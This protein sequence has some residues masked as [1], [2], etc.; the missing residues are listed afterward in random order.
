MLQTLRNIRFLVPLAAV[1]MLGLASKAGAQITNP[2]FETGDYTG[3]TTPDGNAT[4]ETA[5]TAGET[6]TNGTFE[7]EIQT[8]GTAPTGTTS[9]GSPS[10][11]DTVANLD[12]Y[13]GIGTTLAS[14]PNNFFNGSAFKQT[15][16]ANAGS[17]LSFDADFLTDEPA[18]GG[19][20]DQAFAFLLNGSTIDD[21]VSLG[22]PAQALTPVGV[23]DPYTTQTGYSTFTFAASDFTSTG[24]YTI[25]FVVLNGGGTG[26]VKSAELVDNLVLTMGPG[27]PGGGGGSS[28]PL[29]AGAWAG[30]LGAAL[31]LGFGLRMSR[32]ALMA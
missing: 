14:S 6:P 19:N 25:G 7:A 4:V 5:S 20:P 18:A 3:Y 30:L 22:A 27:G 2:S 11:P 23:L 1:A 15:F 8:T 32:G 21:S 17:T 24:S 29:P 13:L 28:V 10:T 12:T 31:A 26:A 9:V 16:S